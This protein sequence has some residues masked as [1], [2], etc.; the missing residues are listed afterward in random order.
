[1]ASN[2]ITTVNKDNFEAEVLKS[3]K[4]V[5]IDF[6]ADWCGPCRALSPRLE[7]F[8]EENKDTVKV[9]KID[10]DK[11]PELAQMFQV[12]SIPTLATM[13]DGKGVMRTVG[14]LSNDQIKKFV[15]DSLK[16]ACSNNINNNKPSGKPPT[17]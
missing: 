4:L 7:K 5:L 6:Y 1:M 2:F 9:V 8:A 13:K 16:A 14:A 17:P 11:S 12:R 10:V 3:D 15:D